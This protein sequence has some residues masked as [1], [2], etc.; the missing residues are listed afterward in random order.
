MDPNCLSDK[1]FFR[2]GSEMG[3]TTIVTYICSQVTTIE[4]M[5]SMKSIE[6]ISK[7]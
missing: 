5:E 4:S 7:V 2:L 6:A 1:L 3:L